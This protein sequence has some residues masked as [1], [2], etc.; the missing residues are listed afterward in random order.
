MSA[1]LMPTETTMKTERN[2]TEYLQTKVMRCKICGGET[3]IGHSVMS[4]LFLMAK[5]IEYLERMNQ[6]AGGG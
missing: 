2:G 5:R 1:E 3:K 6:K 4:C